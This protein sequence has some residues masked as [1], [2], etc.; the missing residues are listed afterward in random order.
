MGGVGGE[1]VTDCDCVLISPS[2]AVP[3]VS[4]VRQSKA[5]QEPLLK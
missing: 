4:H 2:T 3:E 5:F 1:N